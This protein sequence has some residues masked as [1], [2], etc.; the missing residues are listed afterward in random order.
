MMLLMLLFCHSSLDFYGRWV[1]SL[2]I[3][4]YKVDFQ[5]YVY[6][7]QMEEKQY[8]ENMKISFFSSFWYCWQRFV[9]QRLLF[10]LNK[11]WM[12]NALEMQGW[13]TSRFCGTRKKHLYFKPDNKRFKIN[14][15]ILFKTTQFSTFVNWSETF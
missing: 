6:S 5:I 3:F 15:S 4:F 13:M 8:K 9:F 2:M 11:T 14:L 1:H 12:R 10:D 7:C